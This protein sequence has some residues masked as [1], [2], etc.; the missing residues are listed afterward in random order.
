MAVA[1]SA[2]KKE[3]AEQGD[4]VVGPYGTQTIGATRA[5][6]HDGR[7]LG[8]PRNADVEEAADDESKEENDGNGHKETV[9]QE[10]QVAQSR[11][12]AGVL[13]A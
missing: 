7:A 11:R 2:T 12:W 4:V 13:D 5:G 9:T 1:A 8:N 3:P 6:R 10:D